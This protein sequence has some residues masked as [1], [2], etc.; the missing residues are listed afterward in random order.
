[1]K[2]F[3]FFAIFIALM[4]G[5]SIGLTKFFS[6]PSDEASGLRTLMGTVHSV[7]NAES[8]VQDATIDVSSEPAGT[9]RIS[10]DEQG[11][12]LAEECDGK[13][14]E[15]VGRI[16]RKPSGTGTPGGTPE[17]EWV[18]VFRFAPAGSHT[19]QRSRS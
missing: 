4:I 5:L 14:V 16:F 8:I 3:I 15:V 13:A 11:R 10:L 7:K 6:A 18:R 1:M 9:Y 12:K 2:A 17:Q 19:S